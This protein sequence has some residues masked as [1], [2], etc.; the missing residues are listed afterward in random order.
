MRPI[1][2]ALT[3][4]KIREAYFAAKEGSDDPHDKTVR[5][6]LETSQSGAKVNVVIQQSSFGRGL[7][8]T[9]AI[10]ADTP[11]YEASRY[12]IFR[13]E[14]QWKSFLE[15][16]PKELHYDVLM[17][18]YVL[19][20]DSGL[21]VAAVDLDEGSLMNHGEAA[22]SL[23]TDRN[24]QSSSHG[25]Y[26]LSKESGLAN[27]TYCTDTKQYLSTRPIPA[28]GEVLCDYSSF[29]VENHSLKWYKQSWDEIIGNES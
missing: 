22:A 17:W 4:E 19:D 10:P 28:F 8:V 13:T 6:A 29:H 12:G 25:V 24:S 18:S 16:I 1:P 15:R 20:W 27:L 23:D 2:T 9:E 21:Q 7:F 14:A 26:P 3:F 5:A 11:V